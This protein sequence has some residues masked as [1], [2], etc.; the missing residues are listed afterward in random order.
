MGF[1]NPF[2]KKH[3]KIYDDGVVIEYET[4]PSNFREPVPDEFGIRNTCGLC[5]FCDNI[6]STRPI[7]VKHNIQ[8]EGIGCLD[9]TVCDDFTNVLFD[10]LQN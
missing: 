2:K 4:L 8:Y 7:C 6:R 10:M 5:K 1:F 3:R 9:K